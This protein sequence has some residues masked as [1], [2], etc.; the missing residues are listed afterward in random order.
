MISEAITLASA[1]SI[2]NRIA[3]A[4]ME[5]NLATKQRNPSNAIFKLY[6]A[7]A[8]GGSGLIITGNV[9]IDATAMTGPGGVVLDERSDKAAFKKWAQLAQQND[10]KCFMQLNHPG[11]QVPISVSTTALAPSAIP[12]AMGEH[13][14]RF[15]KPIAMEQGDIEKVIDQFALSAKLAQDAGF[16]G[17]QIHAA[18]GYLLSQFLSPISNQRM[19]EWGGNLENRARLLFEVVKAVKANTQDGFGIAVKLNTADFQKGGFTEQDALQV[20]KWLEALN[21]DLVELSGGSYEAPAMQGQSRDGRTLAREAYFLEMVSIM[22]KE[23]SVP[24]MI[25]GGI[26]RL[27]VAQEVLSSGIDMVGMAT[28]LAIQPNLANDWLN[29][30]NTIA[31]LKPIT[32]KNK[33]LAAMANMSQVRMQLRLL[34]KG[35]KTNPSRPYWL[36]LIQDQLANKRNIKAYQKFIANR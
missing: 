27:P 9:M 3:K 10:A 19:D 5:E 30:I 31:A 11:R 36:S 25:T 33:A 7:W 29:N 24:L 2:K 4:A 13:T 12:L 6:D 23:V 21:I 32:W 35:K 1:I 16:S 28:A 22:T 17:I 14:K 34:S 18:H 8:K 15:A 26:R 20:I